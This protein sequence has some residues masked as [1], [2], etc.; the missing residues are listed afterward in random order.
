MGKTSE[1]SSL[2]N[3]HE[4]LINIHEYK[5]GLFGGAYIEKRGIVFCGRGEGGGREKIQREKEM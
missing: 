5:E 3:I 2:I 1:C 4:W